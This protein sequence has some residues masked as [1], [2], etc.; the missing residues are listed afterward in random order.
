MKSPCQIKLPLGM[1][2]LL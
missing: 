1:F 2:G